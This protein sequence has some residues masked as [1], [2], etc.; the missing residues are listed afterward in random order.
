MR[1]I[2]VCLMIANTLIIVECGILG[3]SGGL[4]SLSYLS[5]SSGTLVLGLFTCLLIVIEGPC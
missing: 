5:S 1:S 4:L 2:D 3:L